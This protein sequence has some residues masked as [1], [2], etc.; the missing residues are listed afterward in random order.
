VTALTPSQTVGPFFQL[1]FKPLNRENLA[2]GM[3]AE[4][5]TIQGRVLDGNGAGVDDAVIEIWQADSKGRYSQPE[6]TP[7][8]SAFKGFRRILTESTGAFR[9]TTIKPGRAPGPDG[10]LLAPHLVVTV[11]ARGLLKQLTTRIYLPDEP[12]NQTD[13]VLNLVP[14]ERRSTLIAKRIA[15]AGNLLDWNVILQGVS[16]T[17]FFDV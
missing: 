15:G 13:A 14:P 17:V 5:I 7:G 1:G 3:A 12:S 4:A 6:D 2:T 9:V 10:E 8:H 16:E 11:L